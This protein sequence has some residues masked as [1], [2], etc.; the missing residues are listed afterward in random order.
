MPGYVNYY[1]LS[2]LRGCYSGMEPTHAHSLEVIGNWGGYITPMLDSGEEGCT[3][4]RLVVDGSFGEAKLEVI[5]AATDETEVF[6]DDAPQNLEL[7]LKNP[8]VPVQDK[9]E[10]LCA[11]PH[12]RAVDTQD[13]LL[14]SLRGRYLWVCAAAYRTG[15]ASPELV[16]LRVELPKYSFTEYF[17][18]IYTGDEF[19]ERYIAVFQSLFME[20]EARVD[21]IPRLLDYRTTPPDNVEYLASWLG[22]DNSRGLFSPDQMRHMI[23]NIDIYQGAKGTKYALEQIILLLTGI[24]PKIVEQF[25]WEL[26]KLSPAQLEANGRLYGESAGHFCVILDLTKMALNVSEDDLEQVIEGYCALGSQFKVVYLKLCNHIDTHC[27]LDINSALSVPETVGLDS[28][29]I[30]EHITVG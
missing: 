24:S 22:I 21:E 14:H 9:T 15:E 27:Y 25:E 7:Y 13:L 4:N 16:G 28:G 19:F 10:L 29:T 30:G 20:A 6:I 26:P 5:A 3:F 1:K 8:D 18:E 23:K 17:P 2:L 12:V 11:L